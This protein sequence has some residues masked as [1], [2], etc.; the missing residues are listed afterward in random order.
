[1][2]IKLNLLP[3]E[4]EASSNL[5]RSLKA[6]KALGV[7][8]IAAFLIF[9][10]GLGVF[11]ILSTISL[12]SVEANVTKLSGQVAAM[13]KSEQQIILVEDRI[14]K[15][16]SIRGLPNALTNLAAI[17]PYLANLSQTSSVNQLTIDSTSVAL[18][19]NLK[20]YA[21]LTAFIESLQS[22]KNFGS[23][24]LE[25]FSLNTKLGYSLEVK[26]SQK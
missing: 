22:S 15:I 17:N 25:S 19:L 6:V 4:H 14:K 11:F 21:D 9:G 3:P 1:M 18:S 26:A 20:T 16:T 8:G 7:I 5:N 12:N 24:A 13:Q 23:V 2:A 10:I